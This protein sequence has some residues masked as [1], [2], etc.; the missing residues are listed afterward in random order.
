MLL[1]ASEGG[2]LVHPH[3]E[4]GT[5]RDDGKETETSSGSKRKSSSRPS[6]TTKESSTVTVS[7]SVPSAAVIV[8]FVVK[9]FETC[10]S[11][12]KTAQEKVFEGNKGEDDDVTLSL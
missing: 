4:L 1:T 12:L 5:E 3:H 11:V 10:I 7:A 8:S 2:D 6:S 9:S